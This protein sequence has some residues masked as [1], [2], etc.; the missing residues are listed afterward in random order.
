MHNSTGIAELIKPPHVLDARDSVRRAAGVIRASDGTRMLVVRD[1]RVT[2]SISEQSIAGFLASEPDPEAALDQPIEPLVEYYPVF[3]SSSV[4]A[5][6]AARAFSENGVDML[7]IVDEAG[8]LRGVLYRNDVVA[9]LT[10]NLRP[11]SVGGMATP[12]GVYLT[13]GSINGGA[14]SLGLYLTGVSLALMMIVSKLAGEAIM[15][16][17]SRFVGRAVNPHVLAMLAP[18]D[19]FNL[20]SA[21]ISI[22]LMLALLRLSPLAGYHAAEHMTV[23]AIEQGE[24]L[25]PD[26]VRRMPRVHPR[27]GT[28]LL[29]ALS[30]F[31]LITSEFNSEIAVMVA[32]GVVIL[33]RKAIGDWMQNVFTTKRPNERQLASGI[34]AGGEILDRFHEHPNYQAYGFARVWNMGFLQSAAGMATV[35]TL[36][37]IVE[38]LFPAVRLLS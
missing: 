23:H 16:P 5:H 29:A 36:V 24:D 33:G 22:G 25:V 12:F 18:Y 14:G 30:I 21:V 11:A 38:K 13:T 31:V 32:I 27:C 2:G 19:V 17:L 34:K 4:S 15:T 1:G 6:D 10:R 28:N 3:V 35:L 37:Y 7:P 8:G 20:I 9:L 26:A